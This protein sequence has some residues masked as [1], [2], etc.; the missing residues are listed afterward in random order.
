VI[1][2]KSMRMRDITG[3]HIRNLSKLLVMQNGLALPIVLACLALGAL[4]IAPFLAHAGTNLISSQNYGQMINEMYSADAGIEHAIWSLTDNNLANL[5]PDQGD[6]TSYILTRQVNSLAPNI[7]VTHTLAGG[8][9]PVGTITHSVSDTLQ[10]DS[11]SA[12]EPSIIS[13]SGS[14]YVIAYRG[15]DNEGN[16][17]TVSIGTDGSI[18]NLVIDSYIFDSSACYEPDIILISSGIFAVAYRGSHNIGYLKTVQISGNGL[19]TKKVIDSMQFD[20]DQGLSPRIIRVSGNYYIIAYIG[21]T[22]KGYIATA[23]I[24]SNGA[25]N[26]SAIDSYRFINSNI[27]KPYIINVSGNYYAIAYTDHGNPGSLCTVAISTSGI[28]TKS[29]KDTYTFDTTAGFEPEIIRVAGTNYAIAYRG[30]GNKGYIKTVIISNSGTITHSV[31]DEYI[32]DSTAGYEPDIIPIVNTSFAI[33]YRG[34]T[35]KGYLSTVTISNMGIITDSLTDLFMFEASAGYTPNIIPAGGKTF[36]VAYRGP[37]NK[38]YLKTIQIAN[39]PDD[40][41][42]VPDTYLITSGAGGHTTTAKVQINNGSVVVLEWQNSRS[43]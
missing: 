4:V 34:S 41:G 17:A 30:P 12:Y 36:A 24:A 21:Q 25:M 20:R 22:N 13:A 38:G 37:G 40:T 26:D 6:S 1:V 33:A 11:T 16:L 28:I 31:T 8:G 2:H 19:I 18:S 3:F 10:F 7:T 32:F 14:Y 29:I 15:P 9:D 39:D 35:Y 42:D 27:S 23:Y 43:R 5:I